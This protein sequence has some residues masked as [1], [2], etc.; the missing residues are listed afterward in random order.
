MSQSVP[1]LLVVAWGNPSRGDDALGPLLAERLLAHMQDTQV[2]DR[3][4]VL[5]DFQLQVEHAL[6]LVGRERVLFVD[7]ALDLAE[8]F[9]VR[10][11][12]AA[13]GAGIGS[14]ALAPE[15]VLQVYQDLHRQPPPSATLLAIR[16]SAFD[17][18]S[19]PGAGA[20]AD[21]ELALDWACRW[22]H[23]HPLTATR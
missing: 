20:L 13:R 9:T 11:L 23:G 6:D 18:G 14:H 5:T 8:P 15:A 10:P 7:A 21:M 2:A 22:L 12:Q 16:A 19:T 1:P 3:V 17:L 4:E